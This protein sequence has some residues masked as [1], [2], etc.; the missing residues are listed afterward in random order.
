MAEFPSIPYAGPARA[1]YGAYTKRFLVVH[2]TANDASPAQEAAYARV[3]TDGV[4]MHFASDPSIVLQVLETWYG[5]GHVG[6]TTGNR[7]GLSWEFVGFLS[8]STSYY[9][10]CVDR[11]AD[12]MRLVLAKL[13]IPHR[14]LTDAQLRDGVSRGLVTHLQCSRVLGGSN[15]TDPGPNFPY[16]YLI[17]RLNGGSTVTTPFND[18]TLRTQAQRIDA[19]MRGSETYQVN[20]TATTWSETDPSNVTETNSVAVAL[21]EIRAKLDTIQ[22]GAGATADE[23]LDEML[24]DER[25]PALVD[26][27]REGAETASDS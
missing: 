15:H 14:W 2:C 25:R 23:I 8:S 12:P 4:G 26:I 17:E 13:G 1:R 10:A 7:Y 19:L 3:R 27:A 22:P 16:G 11:A 21:R 6:S 18:P 9:R 5:T 24:S 20:Y